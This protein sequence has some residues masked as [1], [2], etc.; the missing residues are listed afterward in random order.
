M[1][2][3]HPLTRNRGHQSAKLISLLS[4]PF[5]QLSL[6]RALFKVTR[7]VGSRVIS[8]HSLTA[9]SLCPGALFTHFSKWADAHLLHSKKNRACTSRAHILIVA[10]R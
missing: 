3:S 9:L 6:L 7:Q 8:H 5:E 1:A 2:G 10:G 4:Q